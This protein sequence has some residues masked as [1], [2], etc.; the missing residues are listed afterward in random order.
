MLNI[1]EEQISELKKYFDTDEY[2]SNDNIDGLL[3]ALDDV[4]TDVGF[5]E[6]YELNKEGL[7]L[8]LIYDQI[9]NQN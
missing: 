3:M 7:K 1:T 8:Q 2:T 9:Y 5:D 4:I 6:N